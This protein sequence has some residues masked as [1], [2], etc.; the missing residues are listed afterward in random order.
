MQVRYLE[1]VQYNSPV[2]SGSLRGKAANYRRR[3]G[4]SAPTGSVSATG[5]LTWRS[6]VGHAKVVTYH[7]KP[8]T[9]IGATTRAG[10][11]SGALRSR[12]GLS[13][14]LDYYETAALES[15][16]GYTDMFGGPAL[17]FSSTSHVGTTQ[18]GLAQIDGTRWVTLIDILE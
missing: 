15:I 10:L 4:V 16:T 17:S 13:H 11:L 8:F 7:P 3:G 2:L 1:G 9:L 12:F 6:F 14:R 18:G 5:I